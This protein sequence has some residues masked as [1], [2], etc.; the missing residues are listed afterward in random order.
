L[1]ARLIRK[2]GNVLDALG[3]PL[4]PATTFHFIDPW[5]SGSDNNFHSGLK[6]DDNPNDWTRVFNP[7]NSKEDINNGLMHFAKDANGHTWVIVAADRRTDNGEAYIDFE[8]LQKSLTINPSGHFV[9]AGLDGG[10]TVN[11]FVLTLEL[12][13]GGSTAE[14]FVERWEANSHGGFDYVDRTTALPAG[15]TYAAV[16]SSDGTPVSFD[17]FGKNTYDKNTFVEAAVDLTA[18]IGNFDPCLELGINTILI[19]TKESQSP[20]ATIVD[21][22][23]PLNDVDVTLGVADAGKDQIKCSQDASTTF[24]LDGKALPDQTVSFYWEVFDGTATIDD[25]NSLTTDVHVSSAS[26]TIRLIVETVSGCSPA[27]HDD[28]ILTVTSGP[29]NTFELTATNYCAGDPAL[30]SVSSS[31]SELDVSCQLVDLNGTPVQDPKVGTGSGLT[32]IGI[33]PGVYHVVYMVPGG[34]SSIGDNTAEVAENP[35]PDCCTECFW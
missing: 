32:W 23:N 17:A 16:N 9:S 24:T 4:N 14:F 7:V 29:S 5:N 34:C 13:N 26:A 3:V 28:V 27:V 11:D 8:F 15:A 10:R 6:F 1:V 35:T 33:A 18:L 21:Y 22:I 20:S 30:G 25:A 2:R 31:G 19:K 12:T